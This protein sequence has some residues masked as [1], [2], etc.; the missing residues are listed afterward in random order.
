MK[1]L[2]GQSLTSP[3]HADNEQPGLPGED[4][5]VDSGTLMNDKYP[6]LIQINDYQ[7]EAPLS[8]N[9][10]ITRHS[11]QPG[12]VGALGI[13]LGEEN[14]NISNMQVG[15]KDGSDEAIA[16]IGISQLLTESTLNA[17]TEIPAI[18][19]VIQVSL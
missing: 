19:K 7:I 12:V 16:I 11:N 10:L 18:N 1:E 15:V 2:P 4:K 6:R 5:R 17:V 3:V 9:L 13:L 8:G 14:I